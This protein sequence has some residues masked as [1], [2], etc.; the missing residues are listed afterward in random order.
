MDRKLFEEKSPV[1]ERSL[2]YSSKM[3]ELHIIVFSLKKHKLSPKKINNLFLYPTNSSTRVGFLWDAYQMGRKV[4]IDNKF[5]RGDSV[6]S[7]QDPMGIVGYVLAKRFRLPLQLQIHT[8]IFNPYFRNSL[9]TWKNFWY[10]GWVNVLL[11][12]FLIPRA[13][14]LRVVSET[15]AQSFRERFPYMKARIDVL[16]VFVDVEKLLNNDYKIEKNIKSDFPQ[17]LFTIFMASRLS[18]EKRI[19]VALFALQKVVKDFPHTGLIIAGDGSEKRH[20]ETLVRRLGLS[21]NVVFVGWKKDPSSYYRTANM[22]LLTSDYEGYG[23]T[24][25]EAGASGCPIVTTN[26]GIAKTD[27]FKNGQNSYVC[28]VGDVEA[29][30]SSIFD[31]ISNPEKRELFKLQMRDSIK[32]IAI[33]KEEY[34]KKYVEILENTIKNV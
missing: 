12:K 3:E 31:I 17:F 23:M 16:P 20:L 7:A 33:S 5:V 29:V 22:F 2:G 21:N 14:G 18:K 19:D 28:P 15:I 4:I 6:I 30:S 27:V 9:T 34:T 1:L 26:V 24:L 10:S 11:A 13:Q 32:S 8:D 25:V